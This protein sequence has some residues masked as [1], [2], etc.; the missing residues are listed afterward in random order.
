MYFIVMGFVVV[1]GLLMNSFEFTNLTSFLSSHF[2]LFS[3]LVLAFFFSVLTFFLA[4]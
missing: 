3:R 2:T 1:L 4:V